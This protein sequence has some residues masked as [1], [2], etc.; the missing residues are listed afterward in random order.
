MRTIRLLLVIIIGLALIMIA[1]A[2]MMPVDL[3]LVHQALGIQ[4]FS[5]KGVPLAIVIILAV[6]VGLALGLLLEFLRETKFR[7]ML[8]EKRAEIGRLREENA[9]LAKQAGVDPDELSLLPG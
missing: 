4:G 6:M 5:L 3:H 2:N 9:K 7:V 8:N 1:A